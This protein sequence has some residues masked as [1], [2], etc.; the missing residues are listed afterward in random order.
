M[1]RGIPHGFKAIKDTSM[2]VTL[3][4]AGSE[5]LFVEMA[6]L[7]PGPPDMDKVSPIAEQYGIRFI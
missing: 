2:W 7:P 3:V 5:Q 4:P 1:P 6:K